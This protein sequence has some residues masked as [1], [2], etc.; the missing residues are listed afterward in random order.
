LTKED[1][2]DGM[3]DENLLKNVSGGEESRIRVW[4]TIDEGD[5]A[6]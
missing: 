6:I 2:G 5:Q 3:L 4:I 1:Y